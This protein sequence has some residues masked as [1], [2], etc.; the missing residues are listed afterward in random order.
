MQG[1]TPHIQELRGG[2]GTRKIKRVKGERLK[3]KTYLLPTENFGIRAS[4][5]RATLSKDNT[6]DRKLY[7]M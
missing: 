1:V 2:L 3:G 6:K 7:I 5:F 4:P